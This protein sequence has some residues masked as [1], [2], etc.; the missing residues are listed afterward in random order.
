MPWSKKNPDEPDDR[1]TYTNDDGNI[2]I[3]RRETNGKG[4]YSYRI[5]HENLP[6]ES[7]RASTRT[8]NLALA[9]KKAQER[10]DEIRFKEGQGVNP[11]RTRFTTIANQY[12]ASLLESEKKNKLSKTRYPHEK[13]YLENIIIPYFRD[14]YLQDITVLVVEQFHTIRYKE[15]EKRVHTEAIITDKNNVVRKQ[16]YKF[17]KP[18]GQQSENYINRILKHIFN[19]AVKHNRINITEIP[20]FEFN[21]VSPNPRGA[22]TQSEWVRLMEKVTERAINKWA[23]EQPITA[24]NRR[25]FWCYLTILRASG[26]RVGEC[27]KLKWKQVHKVKIDG[28]THI[29]FTNVM[30]K[31]DKKGTKSR[32]ITC[33]MEANK[34]IE[35]LM[36]INEKHNNP[37][38][39]LWI[40]INGKHI[41][42]FKNA[43]NRLM[44]DLGD[45]RYGDDGKI[46]TL[47]SIRHTYATDRLMENVNIVKLAMHMG[48][49]PDIIYKTYNK[50]INDNLAK[51]IVKTENE[52]PVI[53]T[54]DIQKSA[55]EICRAIF[56]SDDINDDGDE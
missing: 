15:W 26:M 49:S 46:R 10:Y 12:L 44:E 43:F 31:T 39:F 2:T 20:E 33:L 23:E 3:Y 45:M 4:N 37:E 41:G 21:V 24:H 48:T 11:F 52:Q 9:Q 5:R 36:K 30:G 54:P 47:Y 35:D 27:Q 34:A 56:F 38:D 42:T 7:E 19:Y 55:E 50:I 8:N 53:V 17:I 25:L 6:N 22:F 29:R 18:P 13:A 1:A 14:Y 40:D 51:D 32:N 16:K 28:K